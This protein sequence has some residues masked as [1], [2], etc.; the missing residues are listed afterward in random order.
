MAFLSADYRLIPPSTGHGIV[1]DV[2]ASFHFISTDL[3]GLLQQDSSRQLFQIDPNAVAAAGAS[4]GGLC[5][6]L[7]VM[8]ARPRPKALLAFYAMG[9][10]FVVS[11]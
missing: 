9:G 11:P 8:H 3:N 1:E 5:A 2:Q 4:A 7:A 10:N 6:Y